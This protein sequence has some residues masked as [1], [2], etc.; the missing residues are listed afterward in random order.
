[1]ANQELCEWCNDAAVGTCDCEE[2]IE[3]YGRENKDDFAKDNPGAALDMD[4]AMLKAGFDPLK[5]EHQCHF[6]FP[7]KALKL[8]IVSRI[9]R[10]MRTYGNAIRHRTF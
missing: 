9:R 5:K 8:K 4:I 6:H 7:D 1:M 3:L 10:H 2:A